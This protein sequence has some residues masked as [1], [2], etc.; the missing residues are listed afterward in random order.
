MTGPDPAAFAAEALAKAS[1]ATPGPWER[2]QNNPE[3]GTYWAI[4]AAG[5]GVMADVDFRDDAEFIAHS[6]TDVE[7]LAKGW[8]AVLALHIRNPLADDEA[9][10]RIGYYNTDD[11]CEECLDA[12]PC[13]TI[14]ALSGVLSETEDR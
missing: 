13:P 2:V 12:F 6:R 1:A 10:K 9:E 14:R 11:V 7:V 8:Q 5:Q 4:H 3:G